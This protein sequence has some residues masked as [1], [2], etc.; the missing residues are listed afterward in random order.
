[1]R[2]Q[3]R[4]FSFVYH[5]LILR[6]P[7]DHQEQADSPSFVSLVQEKR[8]PRK[9]CRGPQNE[10]I[11]DSKWFQNFS[12]S[13]ALELQLLWIP[14]CSG[15]TF[16]SAKQITRS[17]TR[18]LE[19]L[20]MVVD[21]IKKMRISAAMKQLR[22][23][24]TWTWLTVKTLSIEWPRIQKSRITLQMLSPTDSTMLTTLKKAT[25]NGMCLLM[26]VWQANF[27]SA[28]VLKAPSLTTII[29]RT[30]ITN[31][32]VLRILDQC[33]KI[34]CLQLLYSTSRWNSSSSILTIT[35]NRNSIA[36]ERL[37][38]LSWK[39]K[40]QQQIFHNRLIVIMSNYSGKCRWFWTSSW[41]WMWRTA[42]LVN[43]YDCILYQMK[44]NGPGLYD[45]RRW[46]L[47]SCISTDSYKDGT[48]RY[49]HKTSTTTSGGALSVRVSTRCFIKDRSEWP[50]LWQQ[51]TDQH[52]LIVY[53]ILS[54]GIKVAK[55]Q[56]SHNTNASEPSWISLSKTVKSLSLAN[57]KMI[58][59]AL[60]ECNMKYPC[61]PHSIRS[62]IVNCFK[63]DK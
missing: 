29:K 36:A 57:R 32:V 27:A 5:F 8:L 56:K 53:A 14:K 47:S 49:C 3:P 6:H 51:W 2:P 22:R 35:R 16:S 20:T 62:C 63:Y 58:T 43:G 60:N 9:D 31:L 30:V 4:R 55:N 37:I 61:S 23:M 10:A 21:T 52:T 17:I 38:S 44:L 24:K 26:T 40:N 13:N 41:K 7:V 11:L 19:L 59:K 28:V 34:Q 50:F 45:A 15:P 54:I 46:P 48:T 18:S 42:L 1:M 39:S 12:F 25:L 33:L